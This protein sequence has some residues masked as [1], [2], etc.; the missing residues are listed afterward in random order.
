MADARSLQI[1]HLDITNQ[2]MPMNGWLA[3]TFSHTC[4]GRAQKIFF[5]TATLDPRRGEKHGSFLGEGELTWS[6]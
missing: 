1:P 3:A 4:S 2:D 5:S 6:L